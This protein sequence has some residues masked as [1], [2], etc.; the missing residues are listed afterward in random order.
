[1]VIKI[2]HKT[3]TSNSKHHVQDIKLKWFENK[4]LCPVEVMSYLQ[5]TEGG[6][7]EGTDCLSATRL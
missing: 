1:M 4:R 5:R 3:K 2:N 7:N 6:R